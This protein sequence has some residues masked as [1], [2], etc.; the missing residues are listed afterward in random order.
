METMLN[1]LL[2]ITNFKCFGIEAV[3]EE[4]KVEFVELF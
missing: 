4:F 2:S 1:C 3:L